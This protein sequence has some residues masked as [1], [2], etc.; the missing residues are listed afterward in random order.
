MTS[1]SFPITSFEVV[2]FKK[3]TSLLSSVFFLIRLSLSHDLGERFIRMTHIFLEVV[4]FFIYFVLQNSSLFKIK[5][6]FLCFSFYWIILFAWYYLWLLTS[7]L[8]FAGALFF[9]II[10]H[11][12]FPWFYPFTVWFLGFDNF[13]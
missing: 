2:H 13:F 8:G 3:W 4:F 7:L 1:F 10:F 5:L 9:N 11:W 6:F 12:F